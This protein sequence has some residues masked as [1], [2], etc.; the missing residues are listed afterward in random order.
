MKKKCIRAKVLANQINYD[1]AIAHYLDTLRFISI[2]QFK[3]TCN[4]DELEIGSCESWHCYLNNKKYVL[5]C[6]ILSSEI[7]IVNPGLIKDGSLSVKQNKRLPSQHDIAYLNKKLDKKTYQQQN[8]Q[9][10]QVSI[11][12]SSTAQVNEFDSELDPELDIKK[13]KDL[14][15]K[16]EFPKKLFLIENKIKSFTPALHFLSSNRKFEKSPSE[17]VEFICKICNAKLKAPL[18][19]HT[20]LNKHHWKSR[21]L[22]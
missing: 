20:N 18:A 8:K 13:L 7:E 11:S 3:F 17:N 12:Q 1:E 6:E 5:Q 4:V 16:N 15:A 22:K 9:R 19:K 21:I 2:E 10:S 14:A